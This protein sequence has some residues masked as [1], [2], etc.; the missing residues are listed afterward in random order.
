MDY[1]ILMTSRYKEERIRGLERHDAVWT[2]LR[3]SIPSVLVSGT[4]LFAATVGVAI[5]SDVDMISSMCF[6]LARG[7]LVSM[8]MVILILPAMLMA[9]DGLIRHTTAGM[10]HCGG[11]KY[12]SSDS[13]KEQ[14][15]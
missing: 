5:Y 9:F 7:A 1:A 4:G 13:R 8:L 11:K 15:A 10:R 14:Y 2:A 6:L 3:T 12:T